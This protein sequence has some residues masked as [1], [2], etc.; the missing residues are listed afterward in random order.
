MITESATQSHLAMMQDVIS[1]M[2]NNSASSKT[3]CITLVSAIIVVSAERGNCLLSLAGLFP[4][5]IFAAIDV[6]YLTLEKQFRNS[7]TNFLQQLHA[8]T[9]DPATV[10]QILPSGSTRTE[11]FNALRSPSIWLFY[12]ATMAMVVVAGY[13]I[14]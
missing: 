4:C 10:Y 8:G 2:A 12:P 7:Y 6:Y 13:I 5:L 9:V 3:W 11:S 1:R 14:Y